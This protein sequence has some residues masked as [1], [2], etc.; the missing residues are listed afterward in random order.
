MGHNQKGPYHS[1]ET[2]SIDIDED[3][4]EDKGA[5]I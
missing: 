1:F 5:N 3:E 4:V 2:T